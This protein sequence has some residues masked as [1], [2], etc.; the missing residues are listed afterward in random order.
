MMPSG[1]RVM[2]WVPEASPLPAV[3]LNGVTAPVRE[4]IF[5]MLNVRFG[6][7]QVNQRLPG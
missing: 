4:L 3:I 1:S 7:L 6:E 2:P 5:P